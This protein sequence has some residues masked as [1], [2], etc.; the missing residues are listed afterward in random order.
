LSPAYNIADLQAAA[1]RRLPGVV[2]RFIE[3]GAEDEVT[4]R[5]NRAAFEA[6][7][8]APRTLLDVSQRSQRVTVF[9]IPYDCPF[10]I[11]PMAPLGACRYKADIAVARAARAANVPFVL[12]THAFV[13]LERVAREAGAAPWF[14]VYPPSDR[15]CAEAELDRARRAGAEVLVVTTD[16]PVR[17]N[18]EYNDRNGFGMPMRIGLRTIVQGLLHPRWLVDVYFRSIWRRKLGESQTRRDLHDWR[19]FAWLRDAWPGKLVI[20]GILTV[21]DARLAMEHGADGIVISNHGGRQLDG[22]PATLE[23]LPQI[24]AAVGGRMAIFVDGGVRRGADIVKLLALGADM[25]FVGRAALYGVAAGGEA[26][27]RRTLEILR[28]EVD[29]VL[30]FLGCSS[31]AELGPQHLRLPS[32]M[33][34]RRVAGE[35]QISHVPD[36]RDQRVHRLQSSE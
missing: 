36:S 1:R 23:V 4:L 5:A 16:V 35:T 32:V 6:I 13:R 9:G 24:A 21:E 15:A 17:G 30:A 33:A 20:K 29:R 22:A 3:G 18:R 2:W 19:D 10:G 11:S 8:F 25:V 34:A 31:I 28:S 14:Q 27:A 12:S 7:H 26:G